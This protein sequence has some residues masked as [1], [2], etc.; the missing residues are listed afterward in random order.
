MNG[1]G[2]IITSPIFLND[3]QMKKTIFIFLLFIQLMAYG[4]G[5]G[6][7]TFPLP[8]K[9]ITSISFFYLNMSSNVSPSKDVIL[10]SGIIDV[11]AFVLPLV[12]TFSLGGQLAQV[13]VTPGMA[14][15]SGVVEAGDQQ[16]DIVDVNGLLDANVMMRVGLINTPAF[17]LENYAKR[18][19]KFQLS[20]LGGV[21]LPIG[22]YD[23]SRRVNLG[24]NRWAFKVGAPM[25]LPLNKNK[26]KIFQWEFIPSITFFGSNSKPFVGDVKTQDPLLW[27]EQHFSK[28]FSRN[29]WASINM[30]YQYGAKTYIDGESLDTKINQFAAGATIGY[31][32]TSIPLAL[33]ANYGRIWFND[34]SGNVI[35][36]GANISI[37]SK[38]DRE[39]LKAIEK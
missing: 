24:G 38:S 28:N 10:D 23:Q 5:A 6:P 2:I 39:K 29:F 25:I 34:S 17:D 21:T 15:M 26:E 19:L 22:Q 11:D 3:T 20:V 7:H 18:E 37:P 27:L 30:G 32:L 36:F 9:G 1:S 33:Q 13:F 4:Q 14:Y 16:F 12:R 31:S 8:P 35:K